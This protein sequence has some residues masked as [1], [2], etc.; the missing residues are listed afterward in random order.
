MPNSYLH[1]VIA[2]CA[3]SIYILVWVKNNIKTQ[4]LSKHNIFPFKKKN[5][6]AMATNNITPCYSHV[7][8]LFYTPQT[9]FFT[10]ADI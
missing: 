8:K 5:V 3:F 10:F 2:I 6:E 1:R 7:L 4:K 9:K